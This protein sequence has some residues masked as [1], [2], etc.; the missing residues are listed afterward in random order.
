MS[1]LPE[2][3]SSPTEDWQRG[4]FVMIIPFHNKL[5]GISLFRTEVAARA[6]QIQASLAQIQLHEVD[7]SMYLTSTFNDGNASSMPGVVDDFE[8]APPPLN[9][10]NLADNSG[11]S[12]RSLVGGFVDAFRSQRVDDSAKANSALEDALLSIQETMKQ[13]I[14]E[15]KL[16]Y[17]TVRRVEDAF[18]LQSELVN[19]WGPTQ[20]SVKELREELK[21]IQE[22]NAKGS[23]LRSQMQTLHKTVEELLRRTS[24]SQSEFVSECEVLRESVKGLSEELDDIQ[25]VSAQKSDLESLK[26]KI[27]ELWPQVNR[28]PEIEGLLTRS[29][30]KIASLETEMLKIKQDQ[31]SLREL[32]FLVQLSMTSSNPSAN[33]SSFGAHKARFTVPLSAKA[34][35]PERGRNQGQRHFEN[36]ESDLQE[37]LLEAQDTTEAL[38]S[39]LTTVRQEKLHYH[40]ASQ[41]LEAEAQEV[42]KMSALWEEKYQESERRRETEFW[43]AATEITNLRQESAEAKTRLAPWT[44]KHAVQNFKRILSEFEK[45]DFSKA[46]PLTQQGIPWPILV[47]LSK[48]NLDIVQEMTVDNV[49][50]FFTALAKEIGPAEKSRVLRNL[51]LLFHPDRWSGRRILDSVIDEGLRRSLIQ[52]GLVVSQTVN[53][54]PLH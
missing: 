19:Q 33:K 51:R 25:R 47:D 23:A 36:S 49:E 5:E 44:D 6:I 1:Q 8:N 41:K 35:S 45:M 17:L 22:V 48:P 7:F 30:L 10:E 42:R 15:A 12:L 24:R 29:D 13:A 39:E 27:E 52:A 20:E 26:M 53:V 34:D 18:R 43:E 3:Q 37:R 28:L 11:E 50:Y 54:L 32:E 40:R 2:N 31:A 4:T 16:A 21:V 9:S 38:R 14:A 46:H